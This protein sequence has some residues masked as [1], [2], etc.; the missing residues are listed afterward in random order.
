MSWKF[1]LAPRIHHDAGGLRQ[2]A[3]SMVMAKLPAS[4]DWPVATLVAVTKMLVAYCWV[5]VPVIS[6][7]AEFSE[8][9]GGSDRP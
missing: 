5:G 9:P 7:V 2:P 8:S 3:G 6:P 4:F 1:R